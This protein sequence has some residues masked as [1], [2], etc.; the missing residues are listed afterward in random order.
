MRFD[1]GGGARVQARI[2]PGPLDGQLLAGRVGG[3]D[4]LAAA[5]AGGADPADDRVD[6]VPVALGVGEAA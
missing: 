5:I 1:Q 3:D 4:A 6:A 2:V